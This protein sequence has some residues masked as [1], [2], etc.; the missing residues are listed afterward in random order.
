MGGGSILDL[1][2]YQDFEELLKSP[3]GPY[4]EGRWAYFSKV[5][6]IVKD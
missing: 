5:I 2:T 4:Y 1:M 3:A 6:D